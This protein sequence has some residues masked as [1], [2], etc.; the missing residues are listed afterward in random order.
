MPDKKNQQQIL[1][2]SY[3]KLELRCIHEYTILITNQCEKKDG[4]H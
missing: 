4:V 3:S 1:P 2:L